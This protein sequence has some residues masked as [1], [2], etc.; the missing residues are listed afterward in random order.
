MTDYDYIPYNKG[1]TMKTILFQAEIEQEE[2]ERWS[3][4]IEA[5]PGCAVWGYNKEETL[6]ALREAAQAYIEV[7][8]EKGQTIPKGVETLDSPMVAVNV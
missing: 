7:M 8:V 1:K 4:W 2:D 6:E 5:L 3:A